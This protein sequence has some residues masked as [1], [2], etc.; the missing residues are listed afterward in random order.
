MAAQPVEVNAQ[1]QIG[2]LAFY[3]G[4]WTKPLDVA[5]M[6]RTKSQIVHVAVVMADSATIAATS[7]GIRLGTLGDYTHFAQTHILAQGLPNNRLSA[8]LVWLQNQIGQ[9]YGW[10]DILNQ[11]L[12]SLNKDPV[13]LDKS[14]D[15]SHLACCFLWIAG[16]EL[17]P[18]M[19]EENRVTPADL[20]NWAHDHQILRLSDENGGTLVE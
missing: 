4:D 19:I 11:G 15:C 1:P 14:Y 8:A 17:V 20:Y 6:A 5:I 2:D 16:V 9:P 12:L 10:A 7:T 13:L 18:W 3:S